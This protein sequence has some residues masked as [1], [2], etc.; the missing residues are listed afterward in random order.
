MK[1]NDTDYPMRLQTEQ[2]FQNYIRPWKPEGMQGCPIHGWNL[3]SVLSRL[4]SIGVTE[5]KIRSTHFRQQIVAAIP[6]MIEMKNKSGRYDPVYDEDL[7]AAT[8]KYKTIAEEDY[9]NSS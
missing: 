7:S 2:T 9:V 3:S 6:D 4:T 8:G 1:E 5:V